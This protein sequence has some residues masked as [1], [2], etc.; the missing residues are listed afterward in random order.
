MASRTDRCHVHSSPKLYEQ[1][2]GENEKLKAQLRHT[3]LELSEL[4]LQLERATQVGCGRTEPPAPDP[5]NSILLLC[6]YKW[7][8]CLTHSFVCRGRSDLLI[9]HS[10]K[11]RE[12]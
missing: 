12:G 7:L 5:S 4:K 6:R 3:D 1:I 11:W 10:W 2:L 9:G 8:S